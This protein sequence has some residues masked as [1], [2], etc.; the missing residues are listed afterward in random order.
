MVPVVSTASLLQGAWGSLEQCGR[1]LADAVLLFDHGSHAT[2]A[3][4]ALLGREELGRYQLLVGFW[5]RTRSGEDIS[6]AELTASC[7]DHIRKHQAAHLSVSMVAERGTQLDRLLRARQQDPPSSAAF[8]AAGEQ[9]TALDKR[10]TSRRSAERH[11][12]RLSAFY[13]DLNDRGTWDRP[14]DL[15][16]SE[17]R[18]HVVDACNDYVNAREQAVWVEVSNDIELSQAFA[19]LA[20]KPELP[21]GTWPAH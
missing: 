13:V 9:L 7:E 12:A 15:Q 3:G 8:K 1:L 5:R 16:P 21:Q 17:C 18:R 11:H 4:V 10:I 19:Q 14:I 2:A 20:D 6:A